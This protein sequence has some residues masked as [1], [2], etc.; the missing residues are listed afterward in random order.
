MPQS[1][2]RDSEHGWKVYKPPQ[3]LDKDKQRRPCNTA[4]NHS[5]LLCVS[6]SESIDANQERQMNEN[7]FEVKESLKE[8]NF[9]DLETSVSVRK[10]KG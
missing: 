4:V 1:H 8:W 10:V 5:V 9:R 2:V 7:V 3:N 6:R